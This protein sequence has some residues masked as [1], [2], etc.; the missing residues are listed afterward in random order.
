MYVYE[1]ALVPIIDKYI[2]FV[3]NIVEADLEYKSLIMSYFK[4][5]KF[6]DVITPFGT[7]FWVPFLFLITL[8][9]K[10]LYKTFFL[11]HI[12]SF[13]ILYLIGIL[14]FTDFDLLFFTYNLFQVI[15]IFM[16]LIFYLLG[17]RQLFSLK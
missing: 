10:D 15:M 6:V 17:A 16:G 8:K 13:A 12:I 1:N 3:F 11:Y 2:P 9:M 14:I 4:G 7:V 5:Y